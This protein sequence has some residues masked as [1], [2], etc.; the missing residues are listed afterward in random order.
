MR[1][2]LE[3][4]EEEVDS[5]VMEAKSHFTGKFNRMSIPM[6]I[7]EFTRKYI[8]WRDGADVQDVFSALSS[9]ERKFLLT[10]STAEERDALF[11]EESNVDEANACF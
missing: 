4:I 3:L 7:N 10:G 1:A 5:I 9:D 6:N 8:A 2:V 11:K